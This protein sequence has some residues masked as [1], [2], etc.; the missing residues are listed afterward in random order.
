MNREY[1]NKLLYRAKTLKYLGELV[2]DMFEE[3]YGPPLNTEFREAMTELSNVCFR[4]ERYLLPD[5]LPDKMAVPLME[6]DVKGLSTEDVDKRLDKLFD[7]VAEVDDKPTY[8]YAPKEEKKKKLLP[9]SL[10]HI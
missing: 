6:A 4:I 1:S 5:Q 8:Q 9:L 2:K 7:G 10:I 3:D